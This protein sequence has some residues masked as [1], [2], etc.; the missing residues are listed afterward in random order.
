MKKLLIS[1]LALTLSSPLFAYHVDCNVTEGSTCI[2]SP[3]DDATMTFQGDKDNKNQKMIC[4]Y[5][6]A[7]QDI[8]NAAIKFNLPEK[9]YSIPDS[10]QIVSSF[11]NEIQVNLIINDPTAF[12]CKKCQ[13]SCQTWMGNSCVGSESNACPLP[14]FPCAYRGGLDHINAPFKV[15][16]IGGQDDMAIKVTCHV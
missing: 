5:Q 3:G 9:G 14:P 2:A 7:G 13:Y 16:K 6:A 11:E 4:E 10:I 1:A 8:G 15:T 12:V